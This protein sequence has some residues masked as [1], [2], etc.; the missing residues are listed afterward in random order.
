MQLLNMQMQLMSIFLYLHH[1]DLISMF[2]RKNIRHF[3]LPNHS[4]TNLNYLNLAPKSYLFPHFHKRNFLMGRSIILHLFRMKKG[5]I[6]FAQN[7]IVRLQC[8]H[9]REASLSTPIISWNTDYE[10]PIR[11]FFQISQILW[12]IGQSN[13]IVKYFKVFWVA[14]SA[15]TLS[16]CHP[17]L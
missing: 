1:Y 13:R 7:L 16:L 3:C 5:L 17:S 2:C 15:Q 6:I 9:R 14:L 4:K 8:M 10:H 11:L 12:P